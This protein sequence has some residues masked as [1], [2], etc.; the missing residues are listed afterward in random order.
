ME[1]FL[2]FKCTDCANTQTGYEDTSTEYEICFEC[3][4]LMTLVIESELTDFNGL[5]QIVNK[6]NNNG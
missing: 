6:G 3:G 1:K 5:K 4:G 2:T